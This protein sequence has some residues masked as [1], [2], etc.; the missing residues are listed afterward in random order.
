MSR[1]AIGVLGIVIMFVMLALGMPIAFVMALVGFAGTFLLTGFTSGF[2]ALGL[3]PYATVLNWLWVC[4]PMFILMGSFAGQAGISRMSF[5]AA[6]KWLGR[7]PGGLGMATTVACG[8]FAACSG[9]STAAAVTMANVCIPE[10]DRHNYD[11]SFSA[12][13]VAAGGTIGILIPPSIN[14]IVYAQ[15][16]EVSIGKMFAAGVIPGILEIIVYCLVIWIIATRKPLLAPRAESFPIGQMIRS[17]AGLV[18]VII[19]FGIVMG[20]IYTGVF[21]PTEA[22]GLGAFAAF[23]MALLMGKL[24]WKNLTS[25]WRYPVSPLCWGTLSSGLSCRRWQL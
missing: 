15:I 19:L 3:I 16:T 13:C 18:P 6:N 7:L 25:S 17:L 10:M 23:V 8:A 4:I 12:G 2:N 1:Q 11:K 9:S 20:G 22:G 24:K 21:T 5:D 14:M